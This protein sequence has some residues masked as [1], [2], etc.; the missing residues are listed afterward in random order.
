[1]RNL[2]GF[3]LLLTLAACTLAPPLPAGSHPSLAASPAGV[4]LARNRVKQQSW[5]QALLARLRQACEALEREQLPV[6]QTAWWEIARKKSW[7]DIYPEIN[8]H[9]MSAIAGPMLRTREAAIAYAISGDRRCADAV[10]RVLQ[11]YTSYQFFARHPDVGMNWSIWCMAGL[12]SYDLI[13]EAVPEPE[14]R[15]LDDFFSR[16]LAAIMENDQDWLRQGWGGRFN[17]HYAHHKLFIGSYGLFYDK[18]EYVDYAL[19]SEQGFRELIEYAGRDGGL[20]HE[21]S[22][23]YHFTGVEP[24]ADF[25]TQLANAGHPLDL[26]NRQFANGRTLADFFRAP[27]EVLFPDETI[28]TIGDTYGRRLALRNIRSCFEAF[29]A[30]RNPA[31]GWILRQAERP[32]EAFFLKHLPDGDYPAPAVKTQLWPEHGY[33]ALRTQEG[34]D[35]WKGDGF[36]VFLSFDSDGIHSHHDKF[37][38]M[39]FGRGAH[40]AVDPEALSSAAHAFSSQI[41][42]ELNRH[43]VCHNTVMVDGKSHNRIAQKLA[44]EQFADAGELKL[45]SVSD[46][47]GLIYP[48]VKMMRSVAA[49][50]DYV[51]DVFQVWSDQEH[52]YDYLFHSHDDQGGF[53]FSPQDGFVPFELG[54]GA[55]WKWLKNVR[56]RRIDGDWSATAAQGALRARLSMLAEPGTSLIACQFPA[57]DTFR[58]PGIAMLMVRRRAKSTIFVAVL[59]AERNALPGVTAVVRNEK[60]GTLRITVRSGKTSRDVVV[61]R[62]APPSS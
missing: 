58:P 43:T 26:W 33:L 14:R 44:L 56:Q 50:P 4:E 61:P 12:R 54:A 18:P 3:V 52:T 39:V 19:N 23:N 28:P 45:A 25:A 10:R 40:I 42:N 2:A 8:F 48:G 37:N 35:Y 49:A 27:V 41:Q 62:L 11:H 57:T 46:R 17:N 60:Y 53:T 51:L 13:Y 47:Q 30:R 32:A 7:Q 29:S 59:Q 6:F 20:W 31:L 5:A 22:L 55:P 21:S 16:A 1:M 34:A 36:S 24:I 15:A 9:T 38:L